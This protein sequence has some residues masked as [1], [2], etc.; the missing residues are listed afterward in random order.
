MEKIQEWWDEPATT[1]Q[2]GE[3]ED[4]NK[5]SQHYKQ[6]VNGGGNNTSTANTTAKHFQKT[7]FRGRVARGRGRGGERGGREGRG[8]G[9]T[10][11][12]PREEKG[13]KE[14]SKTDEELEANPR[15][16]V[17]NV[18]FPNP[19]S[20]TV[21]NQGTQIGWENT[22]QAELSTDPPPSQLHN[23]GPAV[24]EPS[25]DSLNAE[26]IPPMVPPKIA[27][28]SGNVWA[29][30]G[31]A[32]LIQK[33]K[34]KPP[35]ALPVHETSRAPIQ[36]KNSRKNRNAPASST[37]TNVSMPPT[38]N[39][40]PDET[41]PSGI[42][43]ISIAQITQ[44]GVSHP[45]QSCP[46]LDSTAQRSKA[47]A[48]P[49]V[50]VTNAWNSQPKVETTT[51]SMAPP[52]P[53]PIA[54]VPVL[55]MGRWDAGDTDDNL[56]F[57]FGS[58]GNDDTSGVIPK[59]DTLPAATAPSP[60]RPPPG[61]S[62]SGMPPMPTNAVLV[63]ELEDQLEGVSVSKLDQS[64]SGMA[65]PTQQSTTAHPPHSQSPVLQPTA[66]YPYGGVMGMYNPGNAF[67]GIDQG[68]LGAPPQ[69]SVASKGTP[70]QYQATTGLYESASTSGIAPSSVTAM[71]PST[72]SGPGGSAAT[73][74][75]G[76]PGMPYG[77]PMYYQQQQFHMGQHQP[78]IGYNYGYGG[79][80]S[81]GLQGGFG[82]PGA[83][84]GN[85]GYGGPQY[86][87]QQISTGLSNSSSGGVGY[88]QPKSSS[89]YRGGGG[90]RNAH[91][92]NNNNYQNHHYNPQQQQQQHH[93]GYGGQPY[94]MSYQGDH[95]S[96]RGGYGDMQDPYAMQ[97]QQQQ[98][99][100][101]GV[102]NNYGVGFQGDDPYT[103]S[104][105]GGRGGFHQFQPPH[106][107]QHHQQQVP[108][109]PFGLQGQN[110]VVDTNHHQTGGGDGWSNQ[111]DGSGRG[112][113][114]S[115]GSGTG[116]GASGWQ[117]K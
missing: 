114:W 75:P 108:N 58:F 110:N 65:N 60:A 53:S 33:E 106:Q 17:Q 35:H 52:A 56:D 45:S 29:I 36:R 28:V 86:D 89:G 22:V 19:I 54:K 55:N 87:D 101:I 96:Q 44:E 12:G 69:Q 78:G 6:T 13:K 100:G 67:V 7:D 99:G 82:Y 24:I 42:D 20:G 47:P 92:H 21:V 91:H 105:K 1:N 77:S 113:G 79:Q 88:N 31:S 107:Q 25:H 15:A 48:P 23:N 112:G 26:P 59:I 63:H 14:A 90:G 103:K 66:G 49:T 73:M 57:G 93:G 68:G 16:P 64:G 5:K 74:P 117:G 9:R 34:P 81:A 10:E 70:S 115:G 38:T 109:Q 4:V 84:H 51:V 37:D 116:S 43:P 32:H 39:L 104:K 111:G 8:R 94:G 83:M 41:T 98:Q 11:R 27:P 3:W 62:M 72:T 40:I 71:T 85:T 80:F 102:G 61:L 46:E 97:Q 30:K 76:M 18:S 2:E 50:P 95:F